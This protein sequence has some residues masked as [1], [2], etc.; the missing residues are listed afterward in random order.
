MLTNCEMHDSFDNSLVRSAIP[1][2][3]S[4]LM[5][6]SY[7]NDWTPNNLPASVYLTCTDGTDAVNT[8]PF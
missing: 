6:G 8:N 7:S 5:F 3:A 4:D 2:Q 1:I